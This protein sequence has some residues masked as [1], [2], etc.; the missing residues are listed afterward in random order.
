MSTTKE[1]TGDFELSRMISEKEEHWMHLQWMRDLDEEIHDL[2]EM[3]NRIKASNTNFKEE[4]QNVLKKIW[5]LKLNYSVLD[6]ILV[7][8]SSL[9]VHGGSMMLAFY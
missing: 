4:N 3:R 2:K 1:L 5:M 7:H 8:K 6:S 9:A